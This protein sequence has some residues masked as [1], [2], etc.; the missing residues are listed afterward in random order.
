M[1]SPVEEKRVFVLA[2]AVLST[3][4]FLYPQSS[5]VSRL[6]WS[7]ATGSSATGSSATGSTDVPEIKGNHTPWS[8]NNPKLFFPRVSSH[9]RAAFGIRSRAL[10]T[11]SAL[12]LLRRIFWKSQLACPVLVM[13]TFQRT[14][15]HRAQPSV[16]PCFL[17]C[18]WLYYGTRSILGDAEEEAEEEKEEEEKPYNANSTP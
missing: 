16:R 11:F 6:L 8:S 10:P 13:T 4:L 17:A 15:A 5:Q 2:H 9:P 14:A 3:F 12:R 18:H 1:A 7:S